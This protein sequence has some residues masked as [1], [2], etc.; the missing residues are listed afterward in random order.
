MAPLYEGTVAVALLAAAFGWIE[1]AADV[2]GTAGRLVPETFA[3]VVEA[4]ASLPGAQAGLPASTPVVAAVAVAAVA[5]AWTLHRKAPRPDAALRGRRS[6][7]V[8][9]ALA[10]VAFGL[11]STA[12]EGAPGLASVTVLDVGQGLA[13]LVEDGGSRVLID[14]GPPDAS[15]LA[16][17]PSGGLPGLGPE[18]AAV[19]ITHGDADDV[20]AL[21]EVLRRLRVRHVLAGDLAGDLADAPVVGQALE[22]LDIGD[23]LVLSER[24]WIE[25]LSPPVQTA[26]R[27]HASDNNGS[28]VLMVHIG[29]RRVLLPADIEAEAEEWL[30][31]SGQMLRADVLVAPHH[32]SATSS[33]P[34]FLDAVSPAVVVFSVGAGNRFGHPV[35]DVV[36]R[37][38]EAGA[39]IWRTDEDGSVALRSDGTQLWVSD[40]R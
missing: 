10:V 33:T 23:R 3:L 18:L 14:V 2:I 30:V 1:P 35:E 40:A 25:V 21:P 9:V 11:W 17:L 24:T 38:L 4:L 13:V 5:A 34:R 20:G 19:V 39:H 37:T 36:A 31:T 7:S 16:A 12:L 28:L 8:P 6:L 29:E 15:V 27:A 22:R 32:G 26:R